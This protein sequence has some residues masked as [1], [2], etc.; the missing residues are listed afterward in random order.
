M[1]GLQLT[2]LLSFSLIAL[3][4]NPG[5]AANCN[6]EHQCFYLL[7]LST[8]LIS[9]RTVYSQQCRLRN[10]ITLF[11]FHTVKIRFCPFTHHLIGNGRFCTVLKFLGCFQQPFVPSTSQQLL[12][13]S[14]RMRCLP[15]FQ[16]T[17]RR[18][19]CWLCVLQLLG[20]HQCY[21]GMHDSRIRS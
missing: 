19:D 10:Y 1:L 9:L 15:S 2:I 8:A 11:L 20:L 16:A 18:G 5:I 14:V 13:S 21:S 6:A 17:V 12:E 3:W 7:S 4:L